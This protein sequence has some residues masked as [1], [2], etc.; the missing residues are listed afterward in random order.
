MIPIVLNK[1]FE[2]IDFITNY[3]SLEW[4]RKYDDVGELVLS[5]IASKTNV[6]ALQP[7]HY[8]VRNDDDMILVI[9]YVHL[10][11]SGTSSDILQVKGRSIE[12]ILDR[13]VVINQ[14]NSL[15]NETVEEFVRRLVSENCINPSDTKR[16]IP[17]LILG[18]KK[19]YTEKIKAQVSDKSVL[20]AIKE[21]C[22]AHGYGFKITMNASNQL[23]FDVYKGVDRSHKQLENPFVEF[24][25]RF[26]NV[27]GSQYEYNKSTY[28]NVA[29]VGGE[30]EGTS[31]KYSFTGDLDVSGFERYELF[32]DGKGVS[33]NNDKITEAEYLLLLNEKGNE[34]LEETMPTIEFVGTV[35][36]QR[37]YVYKE[38]YFVGD[39]VQIVNKYGISAS[40]RVSEMIES[41]NEKGYHAV[42]VFKAWEVD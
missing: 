8:V 15:E 22:V 2:V 34:K 4:V 31:K 1:N 40:S 10:D 28:R 6:E 36:N 27:V 37:I 20:E 24:S 38:H 21:I 41:Q 26:G 25:Q 12:I 19:G 7:D 17:N 39:L 35:E 9:E 30:G 16:I 23:V 3:K 42:P 32:V 18:E 14:T 13:R 33:S 11:E 5:A 29:V